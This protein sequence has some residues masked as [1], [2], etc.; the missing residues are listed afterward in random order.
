MIRGAE[1]FIVHQVGNHI[2]VGSEVR[3]IGERVRRGKSWQSLLKD[4]ERQGECVDA[5]L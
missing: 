4:L 2:I 3:E 1:A 5:K